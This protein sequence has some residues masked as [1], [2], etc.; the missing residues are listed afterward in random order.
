MKAFFIVD[1]SG[2]VSNTKNACSQRVLHFIVSLDLNLSQA[3]CEWV[4]F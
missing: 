4:N 1:N 3:N 2:G